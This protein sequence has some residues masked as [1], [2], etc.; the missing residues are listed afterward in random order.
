MLAEEITENMN[1]ESTLL[2]S[3]YYQGRQTLP[4]PPLPR[5]RSNVK[6]ESATELVDSNVLRSNVAIGDE[7]RSETEAI[8]PEPSFF[9]ELLEPKSEELDIL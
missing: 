2:S 6:S 7:H 3:S 4:N 5:T 8:L 1:E 9:S